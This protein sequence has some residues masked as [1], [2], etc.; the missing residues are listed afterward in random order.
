MARRTKI[1]GLLVVCDGLLQIL[2][3]FSQL[4]TKSNK[5]TKVIETGG[6]V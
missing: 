6:P 5:A 3:L 4:K 2:Q 1:E